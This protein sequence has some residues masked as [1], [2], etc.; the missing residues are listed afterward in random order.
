[1]IF[2]KKYNIFIITV[3]ML[4][5]VDF[6]IGQV[7]RDCP[8]NF[9][10]NPQYTPGDQE[11]YPDN[12]VY[13]SSVN[14]A[15]Y[16]FNV[17]T[18]N[19]VDIAPEDWVGAFNDEVCVGARQWGLCNGGTCDVPVFGD[20]GSSFTDG[21]MTQQPGNNIPS[22]KIYDASE[23]IY[24]D[25]IASENIEWIPLGSP[26]IELL[27]SYANIQGCTDQY[28]CN[29]NPYATEDD[30]SCDYCS[31]TLNPSIINSWDYVTGP[32]GN[33]VISDYATYE[34]NGSITSR[35]YIDN[36]DIG[37]DEDIIAAFVGND[38]RGIAFASS[39]PPPLGG[40]YVFNLM[41]FS[42]QA[43]GETITFK[44]YNFLSN[45]VLC[46][47]ETLEFNSD[48][49]IGTAVDAYNFNISSD[50]L[51]ADVLPQKF[52]IN[53]AYPNP[54]NPHIN[55]DYSLI[56]PSEIYFYFYDISGK[57]ID[58]IDVGFVSKGDYSLLW[59]PENI[60]SGVYFAVISNGTEKNIKKITLLK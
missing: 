45:Y 40:G 44:Y 48:M 23:N 18:I 34:F 35:V 16:L 52:M 12:F 43:S 51:S 36:E 20:D 46:L 56:E 58:K 55:I 15:Y 50:W 2:C 6:I 17:V 5:Y 27:Y 8:E 28:A 60:H 39:V 29:F 9:S 21:Y 19:D 25:A 53:S 3:L 1:M 10:I 13:W 59:N 30:S 47:N 57:L 7:N 26:V 37:A 49:I 54:F 22:F 32:S 11:C 31:C 4:L 14:L 33:E 41:V 42:D 24:I 38:L